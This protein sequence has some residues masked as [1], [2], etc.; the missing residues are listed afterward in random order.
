[1]MERTL[2]CVSCDSEYTIEYDED[3]VTG[4][5]CYCPFCGHMY[6]FD[7]AEEDDSW[8]EEEE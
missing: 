5:D 7:D 3:A 2:Q 4:K 8:N 6:D 1:M